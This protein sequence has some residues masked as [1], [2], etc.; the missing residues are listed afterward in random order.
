M[1]RYF[2]EFSYFGKPYHGWQIQPNA[3]SVQVVLQAVL[4]KYLQAPIEVVAAGRTDSGVHASQMFAHFDWKDAFLD[5][6][7]QQGK[8][9][10]YRINKMLPKDIALENCHT[11]PSQAHARFDAVS[12]SYQYH[13][14]LKKN[15]FTTDT[16]YFLNK[17]LDIEAMNS[18]CAY[19]YEY[20]D[21]QC[22]SKSKTDV[23]TYNCVITQAYWQVLDYSIVF[24]ITAD[25]FLR[26]MVRAIVGT[27]I[28]IGLGKF[29]HT[30]MKTVIES[31]S[32]TK[33]GYSVPAH[34]LYLT[35]VVY[36]NTVL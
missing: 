1:T 13:I 19:L 31:K 17:P 12:R 11:V 18:A 16:A 3:I 14:A 30:H 21:F 2:L 6:T 5:T 24:H 32:R 29:P 36:P 20:I 35:K 27:L 34:G 15:P 10:V 9:F 8:D 26:N 28:E 23:K 25:R 4:S 22:F 7:Y 33:A